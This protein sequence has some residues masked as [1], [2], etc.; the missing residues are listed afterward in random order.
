MNFDITASF[1]CFILVDPF[2]VLRL[3]GLLVL[4][5]SLLQA[6]LEFVD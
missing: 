2:T 1:Y 4:I 5:L 3:V 6:L